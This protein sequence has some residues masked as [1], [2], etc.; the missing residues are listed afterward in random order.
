MGGSALTFWRIYYEDGSTFDSTQGRPEESPASGVVAIRQRLHCSSGH[1]T[2]EI[3]K[4]GEPRI[5]SNDLYWWRPDVEE[6]IEGDILGFLDQAKHC[7]AVHLKEG[8]TLPHD[9]FEKMWMGIANDPDFA[10]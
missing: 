3:L 7:G 6:W 5:L 1:H 8:R 4:S 9:A 2:D 10:L